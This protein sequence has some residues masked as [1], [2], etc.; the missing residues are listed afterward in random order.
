MRKHSAP[1]KLLI[2][3][4]GWSA[5][6]GAER[7]LQRFAAGLEKSGIETILIAD[8]RWP[9]ENWGQH[10]IERLSGSDA[11]FE[12]ELY[13]IRARHPGAILF[14]MDRLPGADVFRAGDG[15]HSSW[16]ERLAAEEGRLKHLFRRRRPM[17]RRLLAAEEALFKDPDLRVIANSKMVAEELIITHHLSEERIAVIPNGYDVPCLSDEEQQQ[18][19]VRVRASLGISED[20][21]VFLF[22]GS[23]WK[24]KGAQT[25]VDAF[26]ELDRSD[27]HLILAG[28]GKALRT[29]HANI[30][31]TGPLTDPIDHY[32]ASDV[33][34]L[35]T[36]YDPFSNA[37]LEAAC[38]E[39]PV[40]TTDANGF[41][42]VINTHPSAGE[43]IPT[44]RN[45]VAWAKAMVR[46]TDPALR[47]AARAALAEIRA[48][49]TV[50]RNVNATIDFIKNPTHAAAS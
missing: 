15:L 6:G 13:A 18:R 41:A 16:L 43:V 17:H 21:I 34:I 30:H 10:L 32:L 11:S 33:F 39:L 23:G 9:K 19:R 29:K 26:H 50:S 20:K 49:Y 42:E 22:V 1:L 35:P 38:F 37:C 45:T 31:L 25:A 5:T 28:K 46:W 27:C 8:A 24:R 48:H 14:S 40:L 44:P 47:G 2:Y 4:R 12:E 7:Y 36:L 3:R